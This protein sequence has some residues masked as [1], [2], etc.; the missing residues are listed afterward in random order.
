M[1]GKNSHM[2]MILV[3]LKGGGS[4]TK[5]ESIAKFGCMN[6]GGR[7]YDLKQLG[8]N[9]G[10]VMEYDPRT[11]KRFARYSMIKEAENG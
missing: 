10:R 9:I 1:S 2:E 6:L 11:D 3:H 7:I 4:I 8:H 5:L